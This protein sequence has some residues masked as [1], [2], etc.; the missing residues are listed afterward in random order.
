MKGDFSRLP[1]RPQRHY[2]RVL[3]QQGRPQLDAD[4]NEQVAILFHRLQTLTSDLVGEAGNRSVAP[5]DVAGFEIVPVA[6][7]ATNFTIGAG[8][9]YVGGLC[10][11]CERETTYAEQPLP[12]E[13]KAPQDDISLIYLDAWEAVVTPLDDPELLE[14]ALSG[15][16]TT[17]R[18][19]VVW[20]VRS[21]CLPKE[22]NTVDLKKHGDAF[23]AALRLQ[24]R[25]KLRARLAP[26]PEAGGSAAGKKEDA[27]KGGRFRGPENLL[28]RI[29]VHKG[30]PAA[31]LHKGGPAAE[32]HKGGATFKWS[33]ENGAPLLPLTRLEGSIAQVAPSARKAASQLAPDV[34]LEVSDSH[35]RAL[36]R[37]R[38]MVQV[39]SVNGQTGRIQFKTDPSGG[40]KVNPAGLALRRWDQSSAPHGRLQADASGLAIV[41][42]EGDSEAHWLDIED[43]IQVQFRAAKAPHQNHYRTGDYWLIPARTA[44]DGIL[45]RGHAPE[46]PDG[47]MHYY[48]PLALFDPGAKDRVIAALRS[49]FQPLATLQDQVNYLCE[50][51]DEL[52]R[53]IAE[54][55]KR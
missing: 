39:D 53:Q 6:G 14:P 28:Y 15:I 27:R 40:A 8:R 46:G 32:L 23:L 48:A 11:E 47:V 1:F 3:Q 7:E 45:L 4:W 25:G 17:L 12:I 30:G 49:T 35:D 19:R 5:R 42:V 13:S 20:Q 36:G 37:S 31:E 52:Q 24:P 38:C 41:E 22:G 10:C 34:W 26:S 44:D 18:T 21:H 50:R 55:K 43:G 2:A 54:L 33:R 9:Y 16:E 29:E 51:V